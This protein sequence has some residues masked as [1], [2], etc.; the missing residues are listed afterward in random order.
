MFEPVIKAKLEITTM[1]GCPLMC[2]F[3][4]QDALKKSQP[5]DADKYLS[6]EN[7]KRMLAKITPDQVEIHFSGM[8]EPWANPD[9]TEMLEHALKSGF[10][11]SVYTTL[12]GM[13]DPERVAALLQAHDSQVKT[14]H[15]HLPDANGNMVGWRYSEEWEHAFKLLSA[16]PLSCEVRSMTMDDAGEVHPK[17][18]HLTK[19][20][21]GFVGH[22]RAGLI[23]VESEKFEGQ[24]VEVTPRH[25]TAVFCS[26]TRKYNNN[27]VLPSGDVVLCCMD[28][29]R[30]HII[31]NLLQQDYADIFKT[32]SFQ[33]I[34][35]INNAEGYSDESLCKSCSWAVNA[36][37]VTKTYF[38]VKEKIP[39]RHKIASAYKRHVRP[40]IYMK[41]KG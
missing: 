32:A 11:V 3:C 20:T 26:A 39:F 36:T 17:V 9:C 15:L 41:R 30:K 8:S 23:D 38:A 35:R 5:K 6:V 4:P 34:I 28:Y 2:T 10:D 29:G 31:C 14:V 27:V 7:F 37:P 1:V 13:K 33:K 12:Y 40:L 24:K 18:I 22:S 21:E 16:L 19:R 25:T